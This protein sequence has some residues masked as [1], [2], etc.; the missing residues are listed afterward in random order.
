MGEQLLVKPEYRFI[1]HLLL[2]IAI[3][4]LTFWEMRGVYTKDTIWLPVAISSAICLSAVYFNIYL[5]VPK[6]LLKRWYGVYL[7]AVVYV[8][9]MAYFAEAFLID[10][11]NPAYNPKIR[12][13]YGKVEMNPVLQIFASASS[14]GIL[15]ISSS[16]VVLFRKWMLDGLLYQELEKTAAK[17]ELEQLKNQINPRFLIDMLGKAGEFS[18][19][20]KREEASSVLLQLGHILRYQLYDSTREL[21]LLNTDIDFLESFLKLEKLRHNDFVYDVEQEGDMSDCLV[22]PLL[23]LPFVIHAFSNDSSEIRLLFF[24]TGNLLMF[25]CRSRHIIPEKT[26]GESQH[27][28]RRLDLLFG[29]YTLNTYVENGK[30]MIR[31]QLDLHQIIPAIS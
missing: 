28:R 6:L 18:S 16:A 15:I 29:Q 30:N 13:L 9:I 24:R 7:L 20:D 10:K 4:L 26:G 2:F 5:L 23:F 1:G 25:E 11:A 3:S 27:I 17:K 31:L 21:V 8:I 12:E 22:P 14:L 19:L